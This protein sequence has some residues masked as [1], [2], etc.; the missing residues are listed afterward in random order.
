M[1]LKKIIYKNIIRNLCSE[2]RIIKGGYNVKK[3]IVLIL[4][5]NLIIIFA[6]NCLAEDKAKAEN[7]PIAAV[8]A[9]QAKQPKVVIKRIFEYKKELEL[10]DK[11]E[12]NLK[13]L[14]NNFQDYFA[15]KRNELG[16][17]QSELADMIKTK[18]ALKTIK[19][20]ISKIV[21]L[22]GDITYVDIKT[23]RNIEGVLTAS[24]LAKW[25]KIQEDSRKGMQL[26]AQA[27]TPAAQQSVEQQ[28]TTNK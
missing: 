9:T 3:S 11:Q 15:E 19:A 12:K 24:Q 21:R 8:S 1:A 2:V 18:A 16:K 27:A 28:K 25:V 14:L 23:A 22:Q 5:L 10:T 4:V 17:L 13:K 6:G 26:Q 7:A 20:R